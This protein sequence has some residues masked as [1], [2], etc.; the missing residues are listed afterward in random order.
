MRVL[1]SMGQVW[2]G[3]AVQA[4]ALAAADQGLQLVA[5]V[6]LEEA[7]RTIPHQT[8]HMMRTGTTW[9]PR[10]LLAFVSYDTPY[11]VRQHEDTRL[12]HA[13]GRRAE[14]LRLALQEGADRYTKWLADHVREALR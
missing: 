14:W 7:N 5:E 4:R 11:S 10:P 3:P 12:R 13:P 9:H 2:R 6:L 8:G 1:A